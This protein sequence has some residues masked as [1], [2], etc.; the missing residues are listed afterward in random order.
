MENWGHRYFLFTTKSPA[1]P[2]PQPNLGIPRAKAQ[3]PQRPGNNGEKLSK[4]IHLF[5]RT[6]RAL[7]LGGSQF[8][9]FGLQITEKFARAAQTFKCST[10]V[11]KEFEYPRDC[12]LRGLRV[13]RGW[14]RPSQPFPHS[15]SKKPL[16]SISSRKR[17]STRSWVLIFFARG[18]TRETSSKIDWKPSSFICNLV[19]RTLTSPL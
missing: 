2:E 6:W 9:V 18:S 10:K 12:K 15:L 7:R 19:S 1:R 17:R 5:P 14:S 13:L 8:P 4:I 3:R 16:F 11:T